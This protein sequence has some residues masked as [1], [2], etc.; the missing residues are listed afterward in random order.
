VSIKASSTWY[1]AYLSEIVVYNKQYHNATPGNK[2]L[3]H[4]Y[5]I[6]TL[7]EYTMTSR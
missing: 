3:F 5:V 4:Y 2:D 7:A 6:F 1:H